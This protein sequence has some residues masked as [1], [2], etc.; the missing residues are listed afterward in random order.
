[1]LMKNLKSFINLKYQVNYNKNYRLRDS[2]METNF[3]EIFNYATKH[4]KNLISFINKVEEKVNTI[5]DKKLIN[6]LLENTEKNV[7]IFEKAIS[8]SPESIR[9]KTV[10]NVM[11]EDFMIF[12]P[13]DIDLD[14]QSILLLVMKY[15]DNLSRLLKLVSKSV[16]DANLEKNFEFII[17]EK[18][19]FKE[20]I[21]PVYDKIIINH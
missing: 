1:M 3:E 17:T 16:T 18:I 14:S 13:S 4:E 20:R 5:L 8:E 19:K 9:T 15:L 2:T 10:K 7:R 11:L 12:I 21:E 6:N